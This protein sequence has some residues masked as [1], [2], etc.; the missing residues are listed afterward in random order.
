MRWVQYCYVSELTDFVDKNLPK[1]VPDQSQAFNTIID[2]VMNNRG[3]IFFLD[4]SGGK[5]TKFL[6]NLLLPQVRQ[7][8]KIEHLAV[9][10]SAIAVILLCDGENSTFHI[11]TPIISI[12]R[13]TI[14]MFLM[15]KRAS[16]QIVTGRVTDNVGQMYHESQSPC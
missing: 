13:A 1:L 15:Q 11:Y 5:G 7:S 14:R 16:W 3:K 4:V 9:S 6:A 2:S 12:S 10:S 8:G